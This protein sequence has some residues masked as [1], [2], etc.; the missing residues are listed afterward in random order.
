M[1]QWL[2]SVTSVVM[3]TSGIRLFMRLSNFVLL[4][5]ILFLLNNIYADQI[6]GQSTCMNAQTIPRSYL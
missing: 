1:L 4:T 6:S 5:K 2:L 3:Y